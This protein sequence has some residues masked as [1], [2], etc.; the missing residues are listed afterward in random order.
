MDGDFC[1]D[2]RYTAFISTTGTNIE[3]KFLNL[4]LMRIDIITETAKQM[5]KKRFVQ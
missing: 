4:Q 3:Q 5:M 2:F 1:T